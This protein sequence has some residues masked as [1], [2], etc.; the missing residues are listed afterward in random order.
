MAGAGRRKV[1]SILLAI[2]AG[3]V[4]YVGLVFKLIGLTT[5]Y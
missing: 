2:A 3:T 4:M 1:W 5:N